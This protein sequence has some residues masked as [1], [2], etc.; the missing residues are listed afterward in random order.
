M[1]RACYE[2]TELEI[3][4]LATNWKR[5]LKSL[6]AWTL[7]GTIL[8]VGAGIGG[9]TVV[10]CDGTQDLWICLEPDPNLFS[11]MTEKISLGFL[12]PC[13]K[14]INGTIADLE[15]DYRFDAVL[16]IDV[17]EHIYD[18]KSE[19]VH[20]ASHLKPGGHLIVVAPSHHFLWS[21]FDKAVSHFRR[22]ETESLANLAPI[23]LNLIQICYLDSI[24]M[25]AS[26]ANKC[27]LKREKPKQA[28]IDFW[29]KFVVPVSKRI[30]YLLGYKLGKS[31]LAIWQ[32]DTEVTMKD[33]YP[34]VE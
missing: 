33:Y 13:C 30:D 34:N 25:L 20:A 10:L 7:R 15:D 18:D 31:I 4:A 27:F 5:Y 3:F 6:I 19:I 29:D 1:K 12:P 28:E 2:G 32:H 23:T 14:S 16:Y 8:E 22:Y 11:I 24:G 9:T 26:L 17:L 21:P